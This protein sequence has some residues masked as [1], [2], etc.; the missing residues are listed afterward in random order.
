[1]QQHQLRRSYRWDRW[2]HPSSLFMLGKLLLYTASFIPLA[3]SSLSFSSLYDVFM[4]SVF[5]SLYDDFRALHGLLWLTSTSLF[6]I[7]ISCVLYIVRSSACFF[8]LTSMFF[9]S[10][11]LFPL[12]FS[13]ISFVDY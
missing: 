9:Y 11:L 3:L 4:M 8:C 6:V 1:M 7:V 2:N 12:C 13:H 5:P 10:H